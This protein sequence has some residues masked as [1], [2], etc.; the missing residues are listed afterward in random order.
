[1]AALIS[2]Q[3]SGKSVSYLFGPMLYAPCSM[4]HALCS[5]LYAHRDLH[6]Y[7]PAIALYCICDNIVMPM[8]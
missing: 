2:A 1:M 7:G 4:L 3:L 5:M 8:R 6:C